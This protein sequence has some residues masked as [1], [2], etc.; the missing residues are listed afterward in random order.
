MGQIIVKLLITAAIVG[1]A[2]FAIARTWRGQIDIKK[3]L[4]A[5]AQA[6][7]I[8][9]TPPVITVSY[10]FTPMPIQYE[11]GRK[12][13]GVAWQEGYRRTI[14]TFRNTSPS[15]AL[16]DGVLEFDLPVSIV[17]VTIQDKQGCQDLTQAKS[18][19]EAS[20][21]GPSGRAI[22]LTTYGNH[23]SITFPRIAPDG[24]FT[25]SVIYADLGGHSTGSVTLHYKAGEIATA[26]RK[27]IVAEGQPPRTLRIDFDAPEP[28]E[29]RMSIS[30]GP[31]QER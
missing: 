14:F 5:P 11:P 17:A 20:I 21:P 4:S 9:G 18:F 16:D 2:Y 24:Y 12:I 7:P 6:I 31:P 27:L 26:E 22:P 15:A 29:G 30:F 3:F 23:S 19:G 1:M 13:D 10:G 8:K 28:T 25:L